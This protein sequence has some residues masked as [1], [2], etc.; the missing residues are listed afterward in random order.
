MIHISMVVLLKISSNNN[1][2]H[3]NICNGVLVLLVHHKDHT[4]LR[5]DKDCK[6][7][8]GRRC[9]KIILVDKGEDV[10]VVS[11]TKCSCFRRVPR[12]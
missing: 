8:K 10:V 11:W 7:L 6:D 2:H 5:V 9:T 1:H 4:T 3:S 12:V